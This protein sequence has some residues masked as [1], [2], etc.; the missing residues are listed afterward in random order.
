MSYRTNTVSN[1]LII[2]DSHY[3]D[4]TEPS[5]NFSVQL[6]NRINTNKL[7][8]YRS[9]ESG[10][11]EV[12]YIKYYEVA[13]VSLQMQKVWHN[14]SVSKNNNSFRYYSNNKSEWVTVLFD[15]GHYEFEDI[16]ERFKFE[17]VKSGDYELD[18]SL[19]IVNYQYRI[20]PDLSTGKTRILMNENQTSMIDFSISDFG[21]LFGFEKI[22]I[23]GSGMVVSPNKFSIDHVKR[24]NVHVNIINNSFKNQ[25]LANVIFS[26]VPDQPS[27]TVFNIKPESPIYLPVESDVI[28]R[29]YIQIKD[30]DGHLIDL[31]GSR[32]IA[33]LH[34]RA[35]TH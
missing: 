11:S 19:G 23:G 32:V 30:Q 26:F 29:L 9:N 10:F 20:N 28:D 5:H 24:I 25:D 18:E 14:I 34:V 12:F 2:L 21:K 33:E 1:S 22:M 4:V 7:V 8:E 17:L 15:D 31:D 35:Q 13:L 6:A 27:G 3:E 16:D